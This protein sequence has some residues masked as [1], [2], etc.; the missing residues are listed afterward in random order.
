MNRIKKQEL[1]KE[2][3]MLVNLDKYCMWKK[4]EYQSFFVC[5]QKPAGIPS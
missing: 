5:F 4:R 1:A 3:N 2:L